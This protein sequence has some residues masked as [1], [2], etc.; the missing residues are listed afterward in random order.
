MLIAEKF[1]RVY[2]LSLLLAQLPALGPNLGAAAPL[3]G[4]VI[5]S[6]NDS[7]GNLVKNDC[8]AIS[9]VFTWPWA[10]VLRGMSRGDCRY[11]LG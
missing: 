10:L 1:P 11:E 4:A 7:C 9:G 8:G 3:V 6:L 5:A 2:L